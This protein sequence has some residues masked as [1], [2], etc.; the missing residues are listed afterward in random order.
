M[1]AGISKKAG[2]FIFQYVQNKAET[3][4]KQ[5]QKS[6][7]SC[8]LILPNCSLKCSVTSPVTSRMS[9]LLLKLLNKLLSLEYLPSWRNK[10]DRYTVLIMELANCEICY[11][12]NQNAINSCEKC[13]LV[14]FCSDKN[15]QSWHRNSNSC[16]PFKV[17]KVWMIFYT[18]P[19]MDCA[20][21]REAVLMQ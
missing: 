19:I 13:H 11:Y 2:W 7:I 10:I 8:S 18:G 21:I 5:H 16:L 14:G 4:P 17:G 1:S 9:L 20:K 6:G 15:H 12:C 3:G